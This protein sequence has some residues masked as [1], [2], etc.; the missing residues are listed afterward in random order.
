MIKYFIGIISVLLLFSCQQKEQYRQNVELIDS[1]VFQKILTAN[2]GNVLLVNIWATWCMPCVEEMSDLV[3]LANYYKAKKVKIISIS[4]DYTD[5]I[6]SKIIPFIEKQ[7]LNFPVYV[8][9]WENDEKLI[10][11]FNIEWSGAIPATFIYDRSGKQKVFL[12]G[13]QSFNDFKQSVENL[14]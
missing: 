11:Y 7:K 9:N 14:L 12:L 10:N 5:E 8:N 6:K 2:K 13:K 4:I 1:T 3:K